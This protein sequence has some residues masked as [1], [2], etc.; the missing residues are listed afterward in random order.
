[1]RSCVS[2]GGNEIRYLVGLGSS[3]TPVELAEQQVV[4]GHDGGRPVVG[5]HVCDVRAGVAEGVRHVGQHGGVE[6]LWTQPGAKEKRTKW[7]KKSSHVKVI[8]FG[9]TSHNWSF[10]VPALRSTDLKTFLLL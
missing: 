7:E 8:G 6:V 3:P 9:G 10:L 4:A 5:E 1:M 2:V